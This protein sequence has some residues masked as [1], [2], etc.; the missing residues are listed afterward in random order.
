MLGKLRPVT[1]VLVSE[2]CLWRPV[3]QLPILHFFSVQGLPP[4]F[5]PGKGPGEA[6][7]FI[8]LQKKPTSDS[9]PIFLNQT[10]HKKKSDSNKE[11]DEEKGTTTTT[12]NKTAG[13]DN[14]KTENIFLES[15]CGSVG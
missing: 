5:R 7:L 14:S 1:W 6:N 4:T 2:T 8:Q 10:R 15:S 3:D 9:C 11:K 12:K 13:K